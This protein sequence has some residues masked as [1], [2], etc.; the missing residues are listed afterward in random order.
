VPAAPALARRSGRAPAADL[1]CLLAERRVGERLQRF[2]QRRQLAG[3]A[4][5][6]LVVVQLLVRLSELVG[7]A[8]EPLEDQVE[9]PVG[10]VVL[11]ALI[12][13]PRAARATPRR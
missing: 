7:D 6:V 5:E 11:H 3:E 10:K 2:V 1:W 13:V 12:V 9:A 8:V 4:E